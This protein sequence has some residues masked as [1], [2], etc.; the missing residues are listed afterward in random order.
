MTEHNITL[1]P[2]S[3]KVLHTA[4]QYCDRDIVVTAENGDGS[5]PVLQEKT[6]TENGE[7]LP[8]EGYDG[9]SKVTVNVSTDEAYWDGYG[10]GADTGY[11]AG[12]GEGINMGQQAEYDAFWDAY[13]ENGNRTDYQMAFA[14]MGWN[15]E[16]FQPKYDIK[17]KGVLHLFSN[18]AIT[19]LAKLLSDRYIT[20][21]LSMA[22]DGGYLMQPNRYT[23]TLP[24]LD[25][26]SRRDI[27]HLF[28]AATALRS[29]E[30]IILKSDGT[31]AFNAYSFKEMPVL[32]EIRF[33]GTIGKSLEIKESPLLS[34]ASVQSI[35]DHLK[36]L[37]GATQQTL[38]LHADVGNNMTA[39][40]KAAITAKNW[41]LVY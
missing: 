3:T 38:T 6:V 5:D 25:F 1:A 9:L 37:T 27:N 11:N 39:E 18:C 4:G 22:T 36:D 30:K 21:D 41:Q 40:Q 33:E 8:D 23:T 10:D 2:G 26:S 17:P 12:Y 32:E 29:I 14:G 16:T 31:Q 35:I 20:L 13:Q 24:V 28:Y 19:D 15:D 34:T 7:V